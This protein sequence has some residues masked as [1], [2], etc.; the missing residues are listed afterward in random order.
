MAAHPLTQTAPARI[1]TRQAAG[2]RDVRVQIGA[3]TPYWVSFASRSAT[4][5]SS[6]DRSEPDRAPGDPS[7]ARRAD[8][9]AVSMPASVP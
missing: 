6:A 3:A 7:N 9:T 2:D 4:R 1:C 8:R 5:L